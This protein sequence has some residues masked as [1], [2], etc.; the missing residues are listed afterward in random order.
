MTYEIRQ[1][2]RDTWHTMYDTMR[3]N[4][5]SYHIIASLSLSLSPCVRARGKH[6]YTSALT[7]LFK[8]N[9]HNTRA[10]SYTMK[11][12]QS[13]G[14]PHSNHLRSTILIVFSQSKIYITSFWVRGWGGLE[15][16]PLIRVVEQ[17]AAFRNSY[18]GA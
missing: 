6:T 3:H 10:S 8:H 18:S 1:L 11:N 14:T 9:V 5:Q 17:G 7:S 2:I 12:Y 16:V 13:T 15:T 4:I